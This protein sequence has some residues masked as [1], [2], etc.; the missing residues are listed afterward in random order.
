MKRGRSGEVVPSASEK[1]LLG[2]TRQRSH[3]ETDHRLP[4]KGMDGEGGRGG[5]QQKYSDNH[6]DCQRLIS[7]R[8]LRARSARFIRQRYCA[9]TGSH[10]V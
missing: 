4:N 5:G 8:A 9:A 10:C 6:S 3:P 7:C 2:R 1:L